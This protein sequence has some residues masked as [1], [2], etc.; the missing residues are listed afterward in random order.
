MPSSVSENVNIYQEL[1]SQWITNHAEH[2]GIPISAPWPHRGD[3]Q[4]PMPLVLREVSPS[5]VYLLL[6]LASGESFGLRL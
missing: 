1:V 4:W 5:E 2:C 6:L 3:C